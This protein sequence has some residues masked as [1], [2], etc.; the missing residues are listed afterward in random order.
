VAT[1]LLSVAVVSLANLLATAT[2]ANMASRSTSRA[3]ILAE[4]KM[5][6]LQGL[7]FAVDDSGMPVTDVSSNLAAFTATGV[8]AGS[9]T[10]AALGLTQSPPGALNT[11][12][13]GYVDYV[14]A[15][16]CGLGGGSLPP[17]G[18]AYIRRWSI[19]A[20]D[21]GA[22]TLLLQV[23]VTNRGVRTPVTNGSSSGRMPQDAKVVGAK[24]RRMP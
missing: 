4:Q 21:A 12:T 22:D 17:G 7:A 24:S 9:T 16:G 6:Q 23:L 10:G 2:R 3:V 13:D 11:N 14:N 1:V 19:E 5:E 18:T 15:Q 8:C 20:S